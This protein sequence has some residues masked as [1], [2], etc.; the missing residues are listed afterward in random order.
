MALNA[1]FS[2]HAPAWLRAS[3]ARSGRI[4]QSQPPMVRGIFL[5]IALVAIGSTLY[6]AG[7]PFSLGSKPYVGSGRK[8][9]RDDLLQIRKAFEARGIT[10]SVDAGGHVQVSPDQFDAASALLAK[11]DLGVR[12]VE[13]LRKEAEQSSYLDSEFDKQRRELSAREKILESLIDRL[14]GIAWSYVQINQSRP[15][16]GLRKSP[17]VKALVSVETQDDAML[18]FRTVEAIKKMI[19]TSV[20]EI[21]PDA[22]TI[23]DG[24]ARM[25]LD[26]ENVGLQASSRDRARE[27][28]L[29]QEILE[30]LDWIDRV[31][32]SV[33]VQSAP[34]KPV[35]HSE[36]VDAGKPTM[37]SPAGQGWK[38]KGE[39]GS[40]H[41]RD[42]SKPRI[43]VAPNRPLDPD[44][45]A[46]DP[47]DSPTP[48]GEPELPETPIVSG[49]PTP[50]GRIV[51]EVPRSFYYRNF[52][53]ASQG[54]K[55]PSPEAIQ[56]SKRQIESK[57]LETVRMTI[58]GPGDS[59]DVRV[60]MFPDDIPL[61]RSPAIAPAPES[62]RESWG[63]EI[64][65]AGGS[66]AVVSL[67]IVVARLGR[68]PER[69]AT[70]PRG[71]RRFDRES[72]TGPTPSERVRE[73]VRRNP[74]AAASVLQRWVGRGG[75]LA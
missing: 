8:Y 55:Q 36:A 35:N 21:A 44:T 1:L 50:L 19:V 45:L 14:P 56:P 67:V 60:E 57:V 73:L 2:N 42:G 62:R 66:V 11:L 31:R 39:G 29:R 70:V 38:R 27:E 33:H 28:Q 6:L 74:Q 59:W 65:V 24:K 46:L 20:S 10:Y 15:T 58:P 37:V 71:T 40:A 68:R 16:L 64:A 9:S 49:P 13:E 51:V 48:A 12:S 75:D 5:A 61:V 18:P 34:A 41:H 53:N 3:L 52:M 7:R 69:V 30:R 23:M 43:V 63:W 54:E 26:A 72:P 22:I 17:K 4:F 32:V 25:Y 47:I